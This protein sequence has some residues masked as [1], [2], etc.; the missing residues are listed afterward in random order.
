MKIALLHYRVGENDGVSLEM[1]K[2]RSVLE[3]M[4]HEVTYIAGSLGKEEGYEISSITYDNPRNK[5]ILNNAFEKLEE[6]N[7]GS[8]IEEIKAYSNEIKRSLK[9]IIKR[10][11]IDCIVGSNIWSLGCNLSLPLALK[12]FDGRNPLLIG[13]HHDFHWERVFYSKPTSNYVR[14]LLEDNFPPADLDGHVVINTIAREELAAKK[15][16]DSTVIPNVFDFN[17]AKW[18]KDSFNHDLKKKL[19]IEKGD[20]VFLQAT[21]IVERKAIELILH[22]IKVFTEEFFPFLFGYKNPSGETIDRRSKVHLVL[23]GFAEKDSSE[24]QQKLEAL[25]KIMPFTTH[26]VNDLCL[27]E[28]SFAEKEKKYS[29]WDFYTIADFTT[30]PSILEGWG[31][32]FLES[33][34]AKKPVVV[35]EYPVLQ[36]DIL[37]KGFEVI[38][39]GDS[40]TVNDFLGIYQV[41]R[42]K[43]RDAAKKCMDLIKEPEL[44]KNMVEKNF[45]IGKKNYSYE[46]LQEML[47]KLFSS[48]SWS[49]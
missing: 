11:K 19:D 21:R 7:P 16:V 4:G 12:E 36:K 18:E 33:V 41:E 25:T 32:Q 15:G 35:F 2:W 40:L 24:Y 6:F 44:Y 42:E 27:Q 31:N 1:R 48:I 10:E 47:E 3:K 34:F 8:L 30:Y 22:V 37:P 28:R 38:S 29:L 9:P 5:R 14:N 23:P 20:L 46:N 39:L 45:E 17:D 26:F 43:V 49:E 13:H